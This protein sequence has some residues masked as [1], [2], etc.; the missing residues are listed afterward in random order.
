MRQTTRTMLFALAVIAASALPA[1]AQQT[2]SKDDFGAAVDSAGAALRKFNLENQPKLNAKLEALRAK[3]GWKKT[4]SEDKAV[5]YLQDGR[6]GEFDSQSNE[7]LTKI[8]ALG[9]IEEGKPIDC[10]KLPEL[11]AAGVELLAVMKA[12][13][14]YTQEKID[15]E[16]QGG[17]AAAKPA[18]PASTSPPSVADVKVISKAP[19]PKAE[20]TKPAVKAENRPSTGTLP[21]EKS[22]RPLP[23]EKHA[24]RDDGKRGELPPAPQ[25]STAT[26][27]PPRG[28]RLPDVVPAPGTAAQPPPSRAERQG[29]RGGSSGWE[30]SSEQ[31]MLDN[32]DGGAGE[33][34][35]PP[36]D[37]YM[38][39]EEGYTIEEIRDATRGFFG[40]IS[41][42]LAA[43][44]EYAFSKSGRP[45]A[46]VLGQEGGG[47]FLAGLR[48]GNGTLYMRSGGPRTQKIYWHGPSVGYDFGAEGSRTLFLIYKVHQPDELYRSFTGIDG[49]AYVVGGVG[50]TF[51]KGGGVT[52]APIRT[53]IGL[54]L[55]ANLGYVRFT[56]QPTWNPF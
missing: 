48:Y 14:N 37:A 31:A 26:V 19:E 24:A 16:L 1:A 39:S 13:S 40:T 38:T 22:A 9:R 43:V 11:K 45:T 2:C 27:G 7:L 56:P 46:Y 18:E 6:I 42:N 44:I 17:S 12:K 20:E 33:P 41:T 5:D 53:G 15:L 32:R 36:P 54:R 3:K 29:G 34:Y 23:A 35:G 51:L 4:D 52:M 25:G 49:S 21:A 47:A 50:L 55:G 28:E 8:D 10:G 30:T